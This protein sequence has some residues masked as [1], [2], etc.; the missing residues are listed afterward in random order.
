MGQGGDTFEQIVCVFT[1]FR[2]SFS[3]TAR[4]E[5]NISNYIGGIFYFSF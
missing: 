5:V 3:I 1:D 2:P 4:G